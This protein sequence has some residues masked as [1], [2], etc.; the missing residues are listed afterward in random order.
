MSTVDLVKKSISAVILQG[1]QSIDRD[2]DCMYRTC[3][4]KGDTLKCAIGHLI[5][6]EHY[7]IDLENVSAINEQIISAIEKSVG[8]PLS[9]DTAESLRYVQLS[10]DDAAEGPEFVKSFLELLWGRDNESINK[11]LE[12][13]G[14]ERKV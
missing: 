11:A 8:F 14:Y 13:L 4:N 3:N 6:D 12:E 5:S 10:H 1:E 9:K 2:G 7:T